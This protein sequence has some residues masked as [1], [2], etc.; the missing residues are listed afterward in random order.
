MLVLRRL[1]GPR[2]LLAAGLAIAVLT[3]AVRLAVVVVIRPDR[4]PMHFEVHNIARSLASGRGFGNQYGGTTGPTAH[5]PPGHP[6]CLAALYKAFG[7]GI[8]ADRVEYALNI[9]VSGVMFG[10]LPWVSVRLGLGPAS[11]VL[12]GLAGAVLPIHFL[13]EIRGSG[14]N[15]D[16]VLLMLGTVMTTSVA[17][18]RRWTPKWGV[19]LG[20]AL[21]FGALFNS[22]ILAPAI[23]FFVLSWWSEKGR[24]L[25]VMAFGA[26]AVAGLVL[27]LLPWALHNRATLG[28][29][30]WLRSNLPL[31]LY[32]SFHPDTKPSVHAANFEGHLYA[33]EHPGGNARERAEVARLGELA[34]MEQK[35]VQAIA[36]IR[37]DPWR[38]LRLIA[39]RSALFWFPY[40]G[41]PAQ[42]LLFAS[43]TLVAWAG[44]A[45]L[46]RTG[47]EITIRAVA[48]LWLFFP[49]IYYIVLTEPRYRLPIHWTFLLMAAWGV[50]GVLNRIR[51]RRETRPG[52]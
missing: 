27:A 15:L 13:Q 29:A 51:S 18:A 8:E 45:R 37:A 16:A 2:S 46:C 38:A 36:F 7:T 49:A 9:L 34:Y 40:T 12:A 31:E 21:G 26:A 5:F 50:M 30:V 44:F 48:S 42:M 11:G 4:H 43:L 47:P 32:S 14:G 24:R 39:A 6:L 23:G 10:M 35:R 25:R 22:S 3:I 33:R 20:L 28:K 1:L 41:R 52:V 17:S 19:L